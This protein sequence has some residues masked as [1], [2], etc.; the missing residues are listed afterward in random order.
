MRRGF[1]ALGAVG[2]LASCSADPFMDDAISHLGG[3]RPGVEPGPL[4]R[5]G[6]PCLVCHGGDGPGDTEFSLA[7]TVYQNEGSRVPLAD[8]YVRFIDSAGRKYR[9]ATNCAG[10][11]FVMRGE[12]EPEFPVWV[13]MEFGGATQA[14]GSPIY[15]EGSCAACHDGA[16]DRNSPGPVYFAPEGIPF[17]PGC[18]K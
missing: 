9:T 1:L 7:G 14:M 6:Q 13:K 18:A 17:P 16:P 10:N 2:L 5:P 3:E 11:F 4:H 12:Y 15:R 8:A